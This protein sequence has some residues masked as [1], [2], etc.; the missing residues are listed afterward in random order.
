[1]PADLRHAL[2]RPVVVACLVVVAVQAVVLGMTVHSDRAPHRVPVMV[3]AP[4]AVAGSLADLADQMPGRPFEATPTGDEDA[5][6]Q[7]VEDGTVVAALVVDLRG[8]TDQAYVDPARD[9]ALTEA[10]LDRLRAVEQTYERTVEVREVAAAA[11][12][13]AAHVDN[14]V[15]LSTLGGFVTVLL[16]SLVR[17]PVART[18]RRGVLRVG[19]LAV[20]SLAMA[21]LLAVL[22]GTEV[23]ATSVRL[24]A[25]SFGVSMVAGLLTLA[26]ES[27]AGLAGMAVAAATFFVLAT[28]LLSRTD[29]YLLP[30]P[31]PQLAP[32]AP[33]GAAQEA[34]VDL[35]WFASAHAVRPVLVITAWGLT[36]LLVLLLARSAREAAAPVKVSHWRA[37]VVAAVVPLAALM[38]ATIAILPSGAE[39]ARALPSRASVTECTRAHPPSSVADLNAFSATTDGSPAFQGADVGADVLL[40]DGRRL[41]V[42]GDTLRSDDFEGPEFV[43]NS[44]LVETDSCVAVVLPQDHGA[45]I[46]DRYDGVGYWPMSIG[47]VERPGYDLVAVATQRV[48]TTSSDAFGFENLGPAIAVFVVQRGQ[49]PQLIAQQDLGSDS[50]DKSRPMWGAAMAVDDEGWLYLYGTANPEQEGVFGFSLQVARVRPD[51]VLDRS[52]WRYW[53]GETWSRSEGDA[54][55]L[56]PAEHGVSQTLSV[57]HQHGQWYALSKRD[58]FLG[59]DLM[60]WTAPGPTGPF[61]ATDPVAEIPSDPDSGELRYM[62]LAH[63]T[64]LP[65]K[66]TMVVSYSRNRTDFDEVKQ[67]PS[68]Y[69]PRFLRVPLP[70]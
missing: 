10:V 55:E 18:F 7:A 66:H 49:T 37:R 51:D 12:D 62:P 57:F 35:D 46:P 39:A 68:L 60:F 5:A 53:D 3:A 43:R 64:L 45:L 56:I 31:W 19:I 25:L 54:T 65:K 50:D 61:T 4:G 33:T 36:A 67:D 30:A 2:R 22:P 44:M 41:W 69:R 28:P 21:L 23:G 8:T 47:R 42:F 27:L 6:R 59:S 38:V 1:M 9:P 26:C 58:D 34:A 29:R 24:I 70:D 32:W 16:I 11:P 13:Q 14:L 17:G 20:S 15:L 52:A 48:E 63:P 40:Q